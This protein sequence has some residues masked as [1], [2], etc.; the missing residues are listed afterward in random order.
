MMP[1]VSVRVGNMVHLGG[2]IWGTEGNGARGRGGELWGI[3]CYS[4]VWLI[5]KVM[6]GRKGGL[7]VGVDV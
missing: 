4:S 3:G 7:G 5:L 6:L 1:G 2:G